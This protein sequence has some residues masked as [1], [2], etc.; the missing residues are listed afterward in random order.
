[1]RSR[2]TDDSYRISA[3]IA[4]LS[5]AI[6]IDAS[7]TDVIPLISF[8]KEETPKLTP[9]GRGHLFLDDGDAI[10]FL[11]VPGM[12][13]LNGRVSNVKVTSNT[14][15]QL[16][17]D[18]RAFGKFSGVGLAVEH[19]MP[20]MVSFDPIWKQIVRPDILFF[21]ESKPEERGFMRWQ[22]LLLV[23]AGVLAGSNRYPN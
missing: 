20:K 6:S 9:K 14:T 22:H 3:A 8:I 4:M 12:T 21:D 19:R 10:K 11:E 2:A 23:L 17:I 5:V 7:L 16:D 15:L 1:M 13:E 18:T